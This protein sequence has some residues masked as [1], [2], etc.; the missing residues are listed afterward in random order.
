MTVSHIDVSM[1][2]PIRHQRPGIREK[3]FTDRL[4]ST[5]TETRATHGSVSFFV[6]KLESKWTGF[7]AILL[8]G[9]AW[10]STFRPCAHSL[11]QAYMILDFYE[12]DTD[13]L[14][15]TSPSA[16]HISPEMLLGLNK[17]ACE[18]RRSEWERGWGG[19]GRW[20]RGAI[21]K[22]KEERRGEDEGERER[23]KAHFIHKVWL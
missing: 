19:N 16:L 7:V 23:E 18:K 2:A 8:P 15:S 20:G 11:M 1:N 9:A 4:S 14:A 10:F 12:W 5:F 3:A 13:S 6:V 21:R 22:G 17:I